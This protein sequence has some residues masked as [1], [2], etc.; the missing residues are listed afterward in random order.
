MQQPSGKSLADILKEVHVVNG[1]P[2]FKENLLLLHQAG[3]VT[4]LT[5]NLTTKD[6]SWDGKLCIQLNSISQHDLINGILAWAHADEIR[7]D[8]DNILVLYWEW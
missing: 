1:V 5:D 4:V 7:L 8:R 3:A 6:Q 2:S